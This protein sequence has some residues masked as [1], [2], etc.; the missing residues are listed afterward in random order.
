MKIALTEDEKSKLRA[1]KFKIADL[2]SFSVADIVN[3]LDMAP[4]RAK[5]INALITFQSIP[6]IGVKFAGDLISIGYYSLASLKD[7]D[8]PTLIHELETHCGYWIDPCVEDQ[9]RL[10]VHYANNKDETKS[11]W[12][13]TGERKAYRAEFG[14]PD[15]RPLKPWYEDLGY[16]KG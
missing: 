15:N 8:G 11:W 16:K 10:V 14:Y 13:F 1:A 7:K 3:I 9:C 6:S 2:P 5:E 12:D 4:A